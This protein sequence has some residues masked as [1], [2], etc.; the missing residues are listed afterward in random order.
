[1]AD[2]GGASALEQFCIL[3]K[4]SRGHAAVALIQQVLGNPRI[5]V[6]GELLAA[7][8][9][10]ALRATEHER[11]LHLLEIFAYGTYEDYRRKTAALGGALPALTDAQREKL[12]MLTIV[13]LGRSQKTVKYAELQRMLDIDNVRQLEDIVIETIYAGLIQGK[14]D[15]HAALL[16][17][18]YA[19]A[20][21]VRQEDLPA[22]AARLE[23]WQHAV[24][25]AE[26]A[27]RQGAALAA[28][29]LATDANL[30][31]DVLTQV[32]AA[33]RNLAKGTGSGGG[34][35]A[36]SSDE[37]GYGGFGGGYDEMDVDRPRRGGRGKRTRG[38]AS[39]DL[40]PRNK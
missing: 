31:A 27:L 13:S 39:S 24:M 14:L 26:D 12:R 25:R 37:A 34:G 29:R 21:D 30:R 38:P 18:K 2:E 10:Q 22:L 33:K 32:E 11:T 17:V 3:S 8:N 16:K 28:R 35:G 20:R 7:P 19:M 4:T 1:M 6:F 36:P 9:V 5:F 40:R 15:Q 23:A